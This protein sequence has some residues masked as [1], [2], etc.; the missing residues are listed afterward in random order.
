MSNTRLLNA[1]VIG[2]GVGE[3]HI[4]GY[5]SD[6]RCHVM[7]LSDI[8]PEKLK[9][10]SSRYPVEIMTTDPYEILSN[11]NIDVVSIASYDNAHCDQILEAIKYNKHVF[12]EKPLCLSH[13]EYIKI[14]DAL[15]LK[16]NLHISS[17]LILRKSPRFFELKKEL[18]SGKLG[19]ISYIEG[20][21]DY[22]R[23]H[24][25]LEG[26]RGEIP[27]YSVTLGGGIHLIDLMIWLTGRRVIEVVAYGSKTVTKDTGFKHP[28]LVV[29]LLKFDNGF[30]G[31]IASNFG[32][33]TPHHHRLSVYGTEGTFIQSHAS[34]LYM[35]SR[36]PNVSPKFINDEYPGA[37]KGDMI[38]SFIKEILDGTPSEVSKKDV[39]DVMAVGLAIEKSLVTGMPEQVFYINFLDT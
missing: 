33:V 25:L 37:K 21:Y 17:N 36:D 19:E 23:V 31:K 9:D 14:S 16:P 5:L 26:W 13:E 32:S 29:A 34:A 11:P 39:F 7:A 30:I 18:N 28:D 35:Y 6:S 38:P 15:L 10:V 22:G 4:Q 3:R 27:Y 1:A 24:K 20:S 12:V 8:D 2:L